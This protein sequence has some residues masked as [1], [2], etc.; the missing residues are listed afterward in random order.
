MRIICGLALFVAACSSTPSP[1]VI[2]DD[3]NARLNERLASEIASGQAAVQPLPD[4]ARVTLADGTVFSVGGVTL[5]DRGQYT[6]TSVI[7]ALLAPTLLEIDVSGSSAASMT[8]QDSQAR[9]VS[10]FFVDYGI[11]ATPVPSV[12]P[13]EPPGTGVPV[14]T[15]TIRAIPT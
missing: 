12:M 14:L 2:A 15:I 3:L 9:A 8:V 7:Q 13:Q 10:K 6:V 11:I 1:G 4:G 5:N